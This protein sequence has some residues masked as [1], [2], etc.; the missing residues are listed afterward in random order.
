MVTLK[1]IANKAGLS[2][3]TVS[4]VLNN[5]LTVS[6][7]NRNKIIEIIEEFNYKPNKIAISL[8]KGRTKNVGFIIP[9]NT[10]PF[11]SF[12]VGGASDLLTSHDYYVFLC[13]SNNN[14]TLEEK[15]I[16][17]LIS[18]WVDGLII[19]PSLT[20]KRN[21]SIFNKIKIPFVIVDEEIKGINQD[22]V[23][24]DNKKGA[25]DGVKYLINNGHKN[26]VILG[27]PKHTTTAQDR[28]NGWKKAMVEENLFREKFIF[29]GD[30]SIESGYK[31]MQKVFNNLSD[32][33]AIF[34][35]N[36][37]I[38][39]GAIEAIEEK[40]YKI[41]D[42]ISIVGF[43]DIYISRYLKPP[44]TTIRQPIYELGKIAAKRLIKRMNGKESIGPLKTIIKGELIVRGTVQK[45]YK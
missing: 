16:G 17:D 13:C 27:G 22:F 20:E 18:M 39:L 41:P 21:I 1:E 29:W 26:V 28:F 14:V 23:I 44:L 15:Y 19:A 10:N 11:F 7:K 34:A 2:I 32:V 9:D 24:I 4:K 5:D 36:D 33:D 35:S 45:K 43:D 6:E 31:M 38:A 12:L 40:K 42:D 8:S 37:L 25:Y 3:G 30:F